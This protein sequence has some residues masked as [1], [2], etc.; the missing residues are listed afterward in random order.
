MFNVL[1]NYIFQVVALGVTLLGVAC[2]SIG[3][4][5]VLKKESLIGDVISHASL[6][7][8]CM[9][10]I[11]TREKTLIVLLLGALVFG[12]LA[13]LI[14]NYLKRNA[15][16]KFDNILAL[17]LATFFGFG[18]VL[19][20]YIQTLPGANKAGLNKFIF[21]QASAL[22]KEDIYIIS[23]V[24]LVVIAFLAIFWFK[25][26]TLIFDYIYATTIYGEKVKIYNIIL[27]FLIVTCVII[28]LETVGVIL[29]SS[30][31][32]VPA[33][34][35]RQWTNNILIMVILA[36]LIGGGSGFFGSII[37][38]SQ[39]NLPTGPVIILILSIVVFISLV[40]SPKRGLLRKYLYK[41][42]KKK[43]ILVDLS[44]EKLRG[45]EI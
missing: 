14:I 1:D 40:F 33:V 12:L 34:A 8:I 15:V 22:L 19:L 7:G 9:A 26:K 20:T 6:P 30:L 27:S 45:Q 11:I 31:I 29:I 17:I 5:A 38:S 24:C 25:F 28:G 39:L 36:A 10:Y 21:G 16:I 42:Q 2:G 18:L 43:E 23:S 41:Q 4:F 35:A 3:V 13:M 32:I 44:S 37:S